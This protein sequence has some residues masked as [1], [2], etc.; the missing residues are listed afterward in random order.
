MTPRLVPCLVALRGEF[1]A[2]FPLRDKG[3]DG[4]IGDPAH[5]ARDSDHNPDSR[6][7]V[8][9]LDVDAGLGA[10]VDMAAF[11]AHLVGRRDPRLTYVI[12]RRRIWE[13]S[14][15]W[16]GRPYAG[17]NPHTEHAHISASSTP[18][19]EQDT[20]SWHLE[21]VPVALTPADKEWL[22]DEIR[23]VVTADADP[24]ARAYSLGGMVTAIEQRTAD[25]G[26]R[27]DRIEEKVDALGKPPA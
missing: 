6:G 8:H 2:L 23:K 11:V 3:S 21:E 1:D 22:A 4:W 20:R 7:L 19:R 18:A 9:A 13:A 27:L 14:R 16:A 17:D 15:G 24:T 10:G 25:M 26:R 12:F 5:Q